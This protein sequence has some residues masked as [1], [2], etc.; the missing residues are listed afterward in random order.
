MPAFIMCYRLTAVHLRTVVLIIVSCILYQ[1]YWIN[2]IFAYTL[3]APF[4]GCVFIGCV[5]QVS[6]VDAFLKCVHKCSFQKEFTPIT[7]SVFIKSNH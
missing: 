2:S 4:C 3:C 6:R 5:S 7:V 1:I